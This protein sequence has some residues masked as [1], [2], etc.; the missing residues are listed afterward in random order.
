MIKSIQLDNETLKNKIIVERKSKEEKFKEEALEIEALMDENLLMKNKNKD[1]L[2]ENE[3]QRNKILDLEEFMK[4]KTSSS[5]SQ[6]SLSEELQQAHVFQCR[7]CDSV[8][9][10]S[11]ELA[12][13]MRIVH[14]RRNFLLDKINDVEKNVLKQ[15]Q[16]LTSSIFELNR[17]ETVSSQKCNC[18]IKPG[19]FCKI[20]HQRHNFVKFESDDLYFEFTKLSNEFDKYEDNLEDHVAVNNTS[21]GVTNEESR[22]DFA[23]LYN[24]YNGTI[25]KKYICDQCAKDFCR[26]GGLKKHIKFE[27]PVRRQE[28]GEV[29]QYGEKGGMLELLISL[30]NPFISYIPKPI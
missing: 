3:M 9:V 10:T 5:T 8:F 12:K 16:D 2:D 19:S 17:I 26:Q 6:S 22:E 15:K 24:S 29:Y 14:E 13:H 4:N 23:K 7:K 1:L 18:K 20:N 30:T 21:T 27:H 28:I 11:K 25:P